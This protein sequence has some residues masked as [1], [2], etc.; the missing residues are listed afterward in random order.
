M[1]TASKTERSRDV[2]PFAAEVYSRGE[3]G[4]ESR[5][6][7]ALRAEL[8]NEVRALRSLITRGQSPELARELAAIRMTLDGIAPAPKKRGD[9]V[10]TVLRT[11]GVEGG[12]A[13]RVAT[14]AKQ[15]DAID[16]AGVLRLV[17]NLVPLE[18][19]VDAAANR[20]VVALVGLSGVGKTT[21]AAKLAARARMAGQSVALVS[22][23]GFRVGAF[24]QLERY[25]ELIDASFHVA[26]SSAELTAVVSAETADL[27]IVD[28]AGRT[29]TATAPEAALPSLRDDGGAITTLLC[30]TAAT[31]A[32]DAARIV[33]TF[34]PLG[35]TGICVTKIDETTA[36]GGLV[37]GAWAA[38]LPLS[39]LCNGPRVPEDFAPADLRNVLAA[40]GVLEETT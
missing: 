29:P 19:W 12:A 38:K 26:R 33:S 23:D 11:L 21:T 37:H 24:D 20:R 35:P 27:V 32:T 18:P 30:M 15:S 22:S 2:L 16:A 14:L 9:R 28:T 39:V 6:V 10:A 4:R 34:A 13:T 25:A 17:A 5:E 40:L 31:R 7:D 1:N 3:T 8:R 36:P